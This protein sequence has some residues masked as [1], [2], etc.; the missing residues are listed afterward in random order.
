MTNPITN[1][2]AITEVQDR[3]GKSTSQKP[4]V[5]RDTFAG[6][7]GRDQVTL[8]SAARQLGELVSLAT[9]SS[10]VDDARV[11]QV[12]AALDANEYTVNALR[13]A[14]RLIESDGVFRG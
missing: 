1:N 6:G 9:E 5:N 3:P 8:T 7:G 14:E 4:D 12:R 11:A 2:V 10:D 13:I